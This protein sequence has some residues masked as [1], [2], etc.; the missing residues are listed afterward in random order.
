MT[1]QEI[2]DRFWQRDEAALQA[3]SQKYGGYCFTIAQRILSSREDSEECVN[4]TW[5]NAW[6]SI[7]PQR[8]THLRLYLAKITRS[9]AINKYQSRTAAKRGGGETPLLLEELSQCL[10]DPDGVESAY[11]AKELG[12]AINCFVR[13]LKRREGDIFLRRYFYAQPVR[14]IAKDF[15]LTPHRTT[16]LLSRTRQKLKQYLTQEGFL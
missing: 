5:L 2:I 3:S 15:G 11:L 1:D 8:P 12:Q 6:R 16:V 4:D 7:P 10:T 13:T 9:L 14:D